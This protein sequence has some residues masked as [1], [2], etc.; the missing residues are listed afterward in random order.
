MVRRIFQLAMTQNY[1]PVVLPV[2]CCCVCC[3]L[4]CVLLCIVSGVSSWLNLRLLKTSSDVDVCVAAMP[5][6]MASLLYPVYEVDSLAWFDSVFNDPVL[7]FLC[8]VPLGSYWAR[9]ISTTILPERTLSRHLD[10]HY[11]DDS[12]IPDPC[13][14]SQHGRIDVSTTVCHST[15]PSLL[16]LA[17][18]IVYP[19]FR[20]SIQLRSQTTMTMDLD[21][22]LFD[23]HQHRD[24]Q[25]KRL[26][27]PPRKFRGFMSPT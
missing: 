23:F 12:V 25:S 19:H 9:Q 10:I 6:C 11:P 20:Y 13:R 16:L 27:R 7:F 17:L 21:Y 18:V 22:C 3:V 14:A 4:L 2:F 24:R 1:C 15:R 8:H 5:S 26:A